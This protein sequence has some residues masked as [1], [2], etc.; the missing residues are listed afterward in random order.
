MVASYGTLDA[1][2]DHS[3]GDEIAAWQFKGRLGGQFKEA[4][5]ISAFW[6]STADT[7]SATPDSTIFIAT[8]NNTEEFKVLSFN[9]L[10]ILNVPIFKA[11]GY[12]TG[13]L[14]GSPEEGF[15]VFDSTTKQ[16]KGWNGVAWAVL[17]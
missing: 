14:P 10:G 1:P 2:T 7:A 4:V 5:G 12:A 3:V 8:R 11:T 9:H 15:I 6:S 17:G 13:S 16:F